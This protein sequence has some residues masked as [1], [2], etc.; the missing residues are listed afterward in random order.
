MY[1]PPEAR[2]TVRGFL[3]FTG[4]LTN[5]A[6]ARAIFLK[7]RNGS[8]EAETL[9]IPSRGPS[10]LPEVRSVDLFGDGRVAE[11]RPRTAEGVVTVA[12]IVS[13]AV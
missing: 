4:D 5:S 13:A 2:D 8:M 7:L 12:A 9:P 10:W 11:P 1:F 3:A 6:K